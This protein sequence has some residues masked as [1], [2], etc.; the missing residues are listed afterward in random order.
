MKKIEQTGIAIL[1]LSLM[2]CGSDGEPSGAAPVK[3]KIR[4]AAVVAAGSARIFSGTVEAESETAIG[5]PVSGTVGYIAVDVGQHVAKGQLLAEVDATSM[6]S[7]YDAACAMLSQA[8]DAHARMKRLYDKGSLPEIQW[9]E[10]Q[11]KLQQAE[12]MERIARK[13]LDDCK[14]YAPYAG[15]VSVRGMEVGQ[16]PHPERQSSK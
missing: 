6:Q 13:N 8:R 9:V 5:F 1:C 11:S 4:P 14:I 16:Q 12:S 2:S 7:A 15:V 3:V 10:V